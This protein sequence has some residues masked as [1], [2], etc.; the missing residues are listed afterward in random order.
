MPEGYEE[1]E[2][3]R[4]LSDMR[5]AAGGIGRDFRAEFSNLDRKIERFGRSTSRDAREL[6]ADIQDDFEKLGKRMDEEMRK[7]PGRAAAAGVAI[8]SGTVRA[9]GSARD[10]MW[11]AGHKVK[12]GT[13][14]AFASAAGV[15]SKP[16]KAWT[17]PNADVAGPSAGDD[18]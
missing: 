10:A 13:K 6:G 3:R 15:N 14:S 9:S 18:E 17:P 4:H 1:A 2:F 5:Q 8:G 12:R 11:T 16:M 7:L